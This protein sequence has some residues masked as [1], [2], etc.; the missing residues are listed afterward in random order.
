MDAKL[1]IFDYS[2]KAIAV[3]G[4][5]T[6]KYRAVLKTAGGRFN[7]RLT[8][9]ETGQRFAG[10]IFSKKRKEEL[11]RLLRHAGAP[12]TET[13][14]DNFADERAEIIPDPAVEYFDNFARANNI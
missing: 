1:H 2:P 4:E 7:P 11:M 9:S 13:R 5:G 6:K 10:W 14:P 8:D 3:T 12:C